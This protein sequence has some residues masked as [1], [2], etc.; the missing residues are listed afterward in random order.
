MANAE[1]PVIPAP[2]A[3]LSDDGTE[4]LISQ[5]EQPPRVYRMTTKVVDETIERYGSVRAG[6]LP[7]V[8]VNL[9]GHEGQAIFARRNPSWV[10]GYAAL[11]GDPII[12]IRHE[13]FGWLHFVLDR[14]DAQK[15]G[16]ALIDLAK[17]AP[18]R[19]GQA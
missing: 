3:V 13:G 1:V 7:P 4:I 10:I 15:M 5:I 18:P 8:P 14:A 6:M 11:D 9:E 2:S 12:H 19:A 16:E 17:A